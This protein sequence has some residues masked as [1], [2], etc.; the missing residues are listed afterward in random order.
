MFRKRKKL[1]LKKKEKHKKAWNQC[2]QVMDKLSKGVI[3]NKRPT[4]QCSHE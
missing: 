2:S 3:R 1:I 4:S